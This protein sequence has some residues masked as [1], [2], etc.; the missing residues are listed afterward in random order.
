METTNINHTEYPKTLKNKT[1]DSLRYIIAD[2]KKAIEANPEGHKA[3]FY[4]DEIL[5]C[6]REL[7]SRRKQAQ[8][9]V[10]MKYE[11]W[12]LSYQNSSFSEEEI[13]ARFKAPGDATRFAIWC[14]RDAATK[15]FV[16]EARTAKKVLYRAG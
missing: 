10:K 8:K 16:Y 14:A 12:L 7:L 4:A 3:G 13:V 15:K 9:G 5:Y 6:E 2:C 11:V 1:E